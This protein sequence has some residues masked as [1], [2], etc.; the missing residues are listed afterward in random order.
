M[1]NKLTLVGG[2]ALAL[3]GTMEPVLGAVSWLW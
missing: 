1:R 2:V 3:L